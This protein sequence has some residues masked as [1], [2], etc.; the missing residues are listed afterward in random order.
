MNAPNFPSV[1]MYPNKLVHESKAVAPFRVLTT[2][3][4]FCPVTDGIIGEC[5]RWEEGEM[6]YQT[7]NWA[8]KRAERLSDMDDMV[9]SMVIDGLGRQVIADPVP[10]P[11]PVDSEDDLPF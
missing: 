2:F 3:P 11:A 1:A 10:R 9:C 7:A 5:R 8:G 4:K 6:Y